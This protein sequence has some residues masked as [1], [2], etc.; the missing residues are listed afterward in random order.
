[1]PYGLRAKAVTL[2]AFVTTAAVF[3]NQFVNS[4]ALNNLQ[5]RYYIFYCVFLGFEI[6][7]IYFFLV[8]T[9][10]VPMEEIAKYFDGDAA[11]VSTLTN[12]QTKADMAGDVT[13]EEV[14]DKQ[15]RD[16]RRMV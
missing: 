7:F 4:I 11:D 14:E 13:V 6:V 12:V 15:V 8:E 3:F 10:Y 2:S 5:W 1:M 9:R 16:D